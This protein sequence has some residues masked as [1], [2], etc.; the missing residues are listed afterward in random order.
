MN[1]ISPSHWIIDDQVPPNWTIMELP[2]D[3]CWSYWERS[4]LVLLDL[5]VTQ[6]QSLKLLV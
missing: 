3:L 6:R 4:T 5:L 1:L 2:W